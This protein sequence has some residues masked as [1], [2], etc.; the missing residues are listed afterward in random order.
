MTATETLT[1]KF[2]IGSPVRKGAGA[3]VWFV[4]AVS[5]EMF[6]DM[7][8]YRVATVEGGRAGAWHTER[9]L[10]AYETGEGQARPAYRRRGC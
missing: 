6:S 9:E 7:A 5:T 3:K 8:A 2:E 4:V 10:S 1:P